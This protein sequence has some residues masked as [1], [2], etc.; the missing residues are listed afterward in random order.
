MLIVG[1]ANPGKEYEQTRHNAGAWLVEALLASTKLNL[2]ANSKFHGLYTQAQGLANETCHLLIPTTFMN[3]SGQ[4]VNACKLY[5]K[6]PINKILIAHDD[7]DL[8]VGT[9]RLK[10]G[11]GAGGHNGLKDIIKHL[12]SQ[13]FYR[14]RIGVGRPRSSQEVVDY[15]LRNPSK[16]ERELIDTA[17]CKSLQV[18]PFI[19]T[20]NMQKAMQAL[21]TGTNDLT[22]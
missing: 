10:L 13:D 7:I 16:S 3:L 22:S 17:I 2:R 21:H 9:I 12:N 6:I 4:A 14:L 20:G 18:L 19:L 8:P 11:G 5:H 15:V 1:L